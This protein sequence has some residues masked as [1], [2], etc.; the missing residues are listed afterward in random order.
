MVIRTK[1]G[2][3]MKY[4]DQTTFKGERACF[5]TDGATFTNCIFSDGESPLKE[6]KN[7]ILKGGAFKWKYPLWY[8]ENVEADGC[9]F[10]DNARAGVWYSKNVVVANTVVQAPKNFRR[11]EDLTLKKVFFPNAEET[12]WSCK[13]VVLDSVTV[14]G[15]YFAMNSEDIEVRDL[16]LNGKYSFDGVKNVTVRNSRIVTKDAF[17][18]SENVTV[19]DSYIQSEYLGWNSKNVTFINC[20]IESLQG[21]CYIENLVMRDCKLINTNLAFE[22]SDIDA[23]INSKID[24]VFNPRSG[25]LK[26]NS[27]GELIME[28]DLVDEG[29]TFVECY[30][31][32]KKSTKPEWK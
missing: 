9:L 3:I 13:K 26:A 11:C 5:A 20:T 8:A 10:E 1:D 12:L 31:V 21:L 2:V 32:D 17:W 24:S 28:K 25:Y 19:Y 16:T 22:Y 14:R 4:F 6:S 30:D 23:V 18:N 29:K 7:V 15:D 27:I